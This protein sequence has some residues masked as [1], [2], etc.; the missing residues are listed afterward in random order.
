MGDGLAGFTVLL[1]AAYLGLTARQ[2]SWV[3][4]VLVGG[5]LV[6][7]LVVRRQ[8]VN[9]LS[10]SMKEHRIDADGALAPVLDRST[11]DVLVANFV[12]SDPKE[13]L[14]ALSMFESSQKQAAHPA[15]RDLVNHPAA[16][17]RKKAINI[18]AAAGDKTVLPQMEALL[19]D[20]SLD[21]RTEA[22]LYLAHYAHIDPL[23]RIQQLG[24]F[25]DFSIRSAVAAFLAHPG[26]TQNVEAAR[27]LLST[28][29]AWPGPE[30]ARTRA[31]A[32]RLLGTLPDDFGH[33]L[34]HLLSDSDIGVIREAIRSVGK[35]RDRRLVPALLN[36][37]GNP[38]LAPDVS[39]ALAHFGDKIVGS[40]RDSL[41]DHSVPM[42]VRREIL[43]LLGKIGTQ[44]AS[45]ALMEHVLDPD[46]SFRFLV[47]SALTTLH[48]AN[49]E[50]RCDVQ[51]LETA[52]TAEILGH[53]RS[54]QILQKLSTMAL[55]ND[56]QITNALSD[57]VKREIERIFRLLEL[58]YPRYDFATAYI[59]LQSK[60]MTVHDNALEFLDTV[61]K[62]ELRGMLVPLLDGKVSPTE[63][64]GI[65]DR[66]VPVKID[67]SEQAVATLVASEDPWLR[68]CGAY[69]IG[70]LGLKSLA[71]ELNRC[72]TD[73]D[74]LVRETAS[75]AKVRL[76]EAQA[77]SQSAILQKTPPTGASA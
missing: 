17:V 62:S 1:F 66:L 46:T 19:Q 32:A 40:L 42:L 69:A 9:T 4:L 57:S 33:L 29:V 72:A 43:A 77:A 55:G 15:I 23:E 30:G 3:T 60:S 71:E 37:L 26:E 64:A 7:V 36:H 74:L 52:L 49:L 11:T 45:H 18:L 39:E 34:T 35:V 75:Q 6:A 70:S 47:L 56:E 41:A 63:R 44:G 76:Q 65:A 28:M 59:G 31:E 14:Y 50:L 20:S 54:Y 61:L 5:W 2:I 10:Q 27:E 67:N 24:D 25:A 38:Q 51:L 58:L 21:V 12:A 8:Y 16:E 48:R 68:S 22:L 73:P 53:Y 13:I